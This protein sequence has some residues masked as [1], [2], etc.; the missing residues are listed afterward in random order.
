MRALP[1]TATSAKA[2]QFSP[3]GTTIAFAGLNGLTLMDASGGNV[4]VVKGDPVGFNPRWSPDGSRLSY[5]PFFP[6]YRASDGG[7]LLRVHLVNLRTGVGRVLAGF[8]D[9]DIDSPHWMPSGAAGQ[10]IE[11][12]YV[13]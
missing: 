6:R 3:D 7:P 5:T 8:V 2:S 9:S 12:R 11:N 1:C 10:L 4:R 13:G